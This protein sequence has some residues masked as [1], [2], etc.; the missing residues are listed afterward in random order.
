[1]DNSLNFGSLLK[2]D[3]V[4]KTTILDPLQ[5]TGW[6]KMNVPK[7]ASTEKQLIT[8]LEKLRFPKVPSM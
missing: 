1:M 4:P 3:P 6:D 8:H 5:S 2:L 7:K